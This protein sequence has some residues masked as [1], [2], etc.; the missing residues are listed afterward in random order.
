MG[1]RF[2]FL[3]LVLLGAFLVVWYLAGN[4]IMR[5]RARELAVWSKRSLDPLG[6][7][8]AVLWTTMQSFRLEVDDAAAP[9]NAVHLT[10]LVESWDTPFNWFW[11]RLHGRRDMILVQ[12]RLRIQP[13]WGFELY[14]PRSALGDDPRRLAVEEGWPE[15]PLE[16]FRFAA[17]AGRGRQEAIALLEL[18][19]GQRRHLIRLAVRRRD[20]NLTLALNVPDRGRLGPASFADLMH[21]LAGRVLETA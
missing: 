11:N 20:P 16:E 5:R 10:G 6:G 1:D 14:R 4:E 12:A 9:F 19:A 18:L 8:Q 2:A 13:V 3:A 15:E 21:D 7:S 17:A